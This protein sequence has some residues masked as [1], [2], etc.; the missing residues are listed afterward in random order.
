MLERIDIQLKRLSE[1]GDLGM[2]NCSAYFIADDLQTSKT[3]ASTYQALI[4]GENSGLE[5]ITINT[6]SH[7]DNVFDQQ[8]YEYL[9]TYLRK[10]YHP[11]IAI[12]KNLP[13]VT[14]TALISGAELTIQ[15]GLPQKSIPGLAVAH[16]A[17]FG[18]E[19]QSQEEK[20]GST[21]TLGKVFHMGTEESAKVL[22][23]KKSLTG[24]T[25]V[26]GST[27]AGKSN[28]FRTHE[29]ACAILSG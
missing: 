27:G 22:I 14:P 20:R 13:I 19:I 7:S 25:F 28:A 9:S 29:E 5:A 3:A 12:G 4:R 21:I 17:A 2:W 8:N 1:C 26:T 6:W 15:A 18:R 10:L 24:H 23:D 16:Y 11:E